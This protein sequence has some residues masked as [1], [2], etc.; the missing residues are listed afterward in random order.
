[1]FLFLIIESL[2]SS[3]ILI[4]HNSKAV[5]NRTHVDIIFYGWKSPLEVTTVC[6]V[7]SHWMVGE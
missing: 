4:A 2:K 7:S 1:M 3:N 5:V 6:I